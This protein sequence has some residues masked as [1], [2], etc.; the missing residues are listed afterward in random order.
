MAYNT[1]HQILNTDNLIDMNLRMQQFACNNV[2]EIQAQLYQRIMAND[3]DGVTELIHQGA[4]INFMFANERTPLIIAMIQR[5]NIAMVNH[6]LNLGANPNIYG[7]QSLLHIFS[8]LHD[9]SN[10]ENLLNHGANINCR[11][12]KN[13]TPLH[14]VI[15]QIPLDGTRPKR[16][17][18]IIEHPAFLEYLARTE[19]I[20]D[21]AIYKTI[22]FLISK[23]ADGALVNNK[24]KSCLDMVE[25]RNLEYFLAPIKE[26]EDN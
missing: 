17:L 7:K 22:E 26:P 10:I 20:I 15:K 5:A 4:D 3:Q 8:R 14:V 9:I 24:N 21:P 23:G 1:L 19:N 11:D 2:P 25:E 13:N 18:P 12:R 6:L 16:R